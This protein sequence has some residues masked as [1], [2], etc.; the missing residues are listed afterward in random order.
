MGVCQGKAGPGAVGQR[1]WGRVGGWGGC[2]AEAVRPQP[3]AL[4]MQ[5][6][7]RETIE[8]QEKLSQ[9]GEEKAATLNRLVEA[10]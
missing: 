1:E 9:L 8:M 3:L 5:A 7:E 2:P 10:E 6:S 4:C